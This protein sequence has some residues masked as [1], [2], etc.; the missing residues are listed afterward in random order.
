MVGRLKSAGFVAGMNA[1]SVKSKHGS[2]CI[3]GNFSGSWNF[4]GS[5]FFVIW[6]LQLY[7]YNHEHYFGHDHDH[8]NEH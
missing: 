8:N 7:D 1:K 5:C 2:G 3:L 4:D 6:V